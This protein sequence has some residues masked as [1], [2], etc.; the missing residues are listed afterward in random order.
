MFDLQPLTVMLSSRCMDAFPYDGRDQPLSVLRVAIRDAIRKIRFGGK[1]V[2]EVWIHEDDPG[3]HSWERCMERAKEC[4]IFLALYNGNGGW[5]GSNG[6]TARLGDHVGICHAELDEAM[7]ATRAKV[8]CIRLLPLAAAESGSPNER[9]QSYLDLKNLNSA[10]VTTGEDAIKR[11]KEAVVAALLELAR[12]GIGTGSKGGFH[13]D[14]ALEWARM[15]FRQRRTT[16]TA[17]V[18]GLLERRFGGRVLADQ[19]VVCPMA[20]EEVAFKCDSVPGSMGT[21][22]ARELVGQPFLDDWK[23]SSRLPEG[24][25]GPVHVISCQK[26]VTESQAIR[27]LGFPDAVV[28]SAPFG[29]YVA[30]RV[31]CIQMVFIANCRDETTTR[32]RT[33][34]FLTWLLEQ[35]EEALLVRR[36]ISRRKIC[37]AIASECESWH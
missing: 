34:M 37:G 21:A 36:A 32:T 23:V 1:P 20:G 9:F 14:Q 33:Q 25:A 31:Q 11:S 13:T 5:S 18:A 26:G 24:V 16:T 28:V 27:Q 22:A 4:D 8:R 3:G 30:D 15:D 35:G 7:H 19:V 17:V 12:M 10:Q 6:S 29:V 2:F